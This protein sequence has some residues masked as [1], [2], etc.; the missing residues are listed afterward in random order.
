M[1]SGL[2]FKAPRP[3]QT[4]RR[5]APSQLNLQLLQGRKRAPRRPEGTIVV[6]LPTHFAK[7]N[8]VSLPN[9]RRSHY[10]RSCFPGLRGPTAGL[11]SFASCA[12]L[13]APASSASLRSACG[14]RLRRP[15][16]P[17]HGIQ[18]PAK[19]KAPVVRTPGPL[20]LKTEGRF[21]GMLRETSSS[22]FKP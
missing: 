7:Q 16:N 2:A 21:N 14:G 22:S 3:H 8:G 12:R 4:H 9:L 13:A 20:Q 19:E 18:A 5:P 10:V 1:P 17:C 6:G 15:S 11:L